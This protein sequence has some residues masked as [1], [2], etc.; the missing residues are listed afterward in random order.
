MILAQLGARRRLEPDWYSFCWAAVPRT[1]NSR[2]TRD[3]SSSLSAP[4]LSLPPSLA[5]ALSFSR[6]LSEPMDGRT[7]RPR[8]MQALQRQIP[9]LWLQREEA[10]AADL[11]RQLPN[12]AGT[13][14]ASRVACIRHGLPRVFL[15]ALQNT[16]FAFEQRISDALLCRPPMCQPFSGRSQLPSQVTISFSTVLR[17]CTLVLDSA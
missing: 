1:T 11:A 17:P 8:I 4:L 10:A 12:R 16:A 15:T 13:D 2:G 9:L 5:L 3:A 14:G 6:T 7:L